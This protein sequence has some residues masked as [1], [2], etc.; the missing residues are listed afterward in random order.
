MKKGRFV[1]RLIVTSM[2]VATGIGGVVVFKGRASAQPEEGAIV[3]VARGSVRIGVQE[4]GSVEAFRKVELKSKIA[5]QVAEVLVDVGSKVKAGD[6]LVRL[7]PRDAKRE[8]AQVEARRGVDEAALGQSSSMLDIQKKA[9]AQGGLSAIEVTKTDGDVKRYRAQLGVDSADRAILQDRVGYTE[10]RAP[11][12][13]V[14]LARNVQPGEMVTPGVAAMVDGKP[15]LV[16]AQVERLLVRAELNQIDVVRLGPDQKV[17][18]KVDALPGKTFEG[19]VFRIA[20]MAQRSERRKD[21]NLMVFPVDVVVDASQPGA[22]ALRPG[23]LSD[24]TVDLG[25]HDGVLRVPLESLVRE[26]DKTQLR[27]LDAKDKE[28]LV[29]VTVGAQNEQ[30]VEIVSGIGEGDRIRVR[31][32]NAKK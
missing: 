28:T 12:D 6:V 16:V 19:H 10:L 18:V 26:G 7:D 5:G 3:T 24:I 17:S 32:E 20:A 2:I 27:R 22:D 23:M 1:K 9:L 14:V 30:F 15:L 21:S 13:G 25:S 31:P 8:L 4:V 29:D 11:I